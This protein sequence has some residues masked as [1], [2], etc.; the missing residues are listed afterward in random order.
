[1]GKP[2]RCFIDEKG[3]IFKTESLHRAA[4]NIPVTTY[5]IN[6]DAILDELIRW[7]LDNFR[8]FMNHFKR[9]KDADLSKPLIVRSDGYVMD[10]WHR[11]IRA[12]LEGITDLPQKRF[13]VDPEPDE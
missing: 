1:M 8:D 6:V 10:G 13:I 9:V 3:R 12:I 11:I 5:H 4:E 7:R 2:G